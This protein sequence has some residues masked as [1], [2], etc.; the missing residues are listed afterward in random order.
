MATNSAYYLF[1]PILLVLGIAGNTMG[2]RVLLKK[3]LKKIGP[4]LIYNILFISDTIY[5]GALLFVAF[6]SKAAKI[7]K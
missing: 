6:V 1:P 3:N 7:Q 4:V 2:L 5:L